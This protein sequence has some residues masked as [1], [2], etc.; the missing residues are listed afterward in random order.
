MT[1]SQDP[2]TKSMIAWLIKSVAGKDSDCFT[3]TL[4][5]FLVM[6]TQTGWQGVEWAQPREPKKTSILYV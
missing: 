6:G 1:K 4:G 5:D 2:I 3:S